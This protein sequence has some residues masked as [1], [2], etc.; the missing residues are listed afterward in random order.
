MEQAGVPRSVAMKITG[1]RTESMYRRYAI[2]S[3][4]ELKRAAEQIA[5][6]SGTLSGT[7]A[8]VRPMRH[9]RAAGQSGS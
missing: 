3:P 1:Q 9:T 2:V 8:P 6:G 7:V 5:A 4:A